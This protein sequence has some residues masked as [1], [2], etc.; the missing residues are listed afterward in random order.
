MTENFG[1]CYSCLLW[2]NP[3]DFNTYG[4]CNLH[5]GSTTYTH[6]M[7]RC[8]NYIPYTQYSEWIVKDIINKR[9][10]EVKE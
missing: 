6:H 7:C 3:V 5:R 9:F 1:K 4:K 10:G 2:S 8:D